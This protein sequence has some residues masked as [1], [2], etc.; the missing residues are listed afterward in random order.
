MKNRLIM[1]FLL[2]V[3]GCWFNLWPGAVGAQEMESADVFVRVEAVLGQ[4][5]RIRF[6]MGK[7]KIREEI[8]VVKGAAQRE[9]FFQALTLCKKADRL[10]FEQ[11]R[12][13]GPLP[14]VPGGAIEAKHVAEVIDELLARINRIETS[15][16][17]DSA[18]DPTP[19]DPKKSA[20]DV[21]HAI[22]VANRRINILLE[23][24]ISPSDVY[25]E[26]TLA[27]SYASGLLAAVPGAE[28][29]PDPLAFEPGKQPADV[30]LRLVGC[31]GIVR[32]IARSSGLELLELTPVQGT[33]YD[34]EAVVP[35]DV[36]EISSLLVSE[37]KYLHGKLPQAAP[38]REVYYPG[39][40][41][42]SHVFQRVG[43]LEAQL[44]QLENHSK[45]NPN[46]LRD[47][48]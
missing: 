8:F 46:W 33:K 34:T 47:D 10:C 2:M 18:T 38:P 14:A 3:P 29:N 22:V 39:P 4:L 45:A 12:E 15:P 1:L 11:L 16:P 35:S 9:V 43:I 44:E 37:L 27:M 48:P 20:T 19:R 30:F 7:P 40:K 6:D 26:V 42:P 21:Y 28:R 41:F 31:F 17:V 5:E 24:Q 36:F 13:R 32:N 25:Q 23:K